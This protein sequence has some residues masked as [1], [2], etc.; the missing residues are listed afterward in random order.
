MRL[1]KIDSSALTFRN[2]RVWTDNLLWSWRKL[3]EKK[4]VPDKK[5]VPSYLSWKRKQ[6]YGLHK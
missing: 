1:V 2:A 5:V 3:I 6:V 4:N